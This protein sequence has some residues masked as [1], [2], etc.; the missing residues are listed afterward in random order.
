MVRVIVS[1]VAVAMMTLLSVASAVS[2]QEEALQF[3]SLDIQ[4]YVHRLQAALKDSNGADQELLKHVEYYKRI[5]G[6]VAHT[7]RDFE[8]GAVY[9]CVPFRHQPALIDAQRTLVEQA[10]KAHESSLVRSQERNAELT[11]RFGAESNKCPSD[12]VP[13]ARPVVAY[14]GSNRLSLSKPKA[15]KASIKKMAPIPA[16]Y[17]YVDSAFANVSTN[18]TYTILGVGKLVGAPQPSTPFLNFDDHSINQM[19]WI[20]LGKN[21]S[22]L[23]SLETGWIHCAYFSF[24]PMTSLFTFSTPDGYGPSNY[25]QYNMAGDFIMYATGPPLGVGME[26]I[27]YMFRWEIMANNTGYELWL[28]PFNESNNGIYYTFGDWIPTGY[29]PSNRYNGVPVLN[30][31]QTGQELAQNAN[32]TSLTASGKIFGWGT[33]DAAFPIQGNF[34]NFGQH[35]SFNYGNFP[36]FNDNPYSANHY[37]HFHGDDEPTPAPSA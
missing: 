21:A 11:T 34:T 12:T 23:V 25:N 9:D 15:K 30:V 22:H 17:S 35:I 13:V 5:A 32:S 31:L 3:A 8:H 36:I 16:G 1:V 7:E 26:N 19:W 33:A 2:L 20:H 27:M 24:F 6:E 18:K 10:M 29:F 37:V 4:G 14:R 28:R